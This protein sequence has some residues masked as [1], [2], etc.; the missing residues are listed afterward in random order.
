M[1]VQIVLDKKTIEDYLKNAV[2]QEPK[3]MVA[4]LVDKVFVHCGHIELIPHYADKPI[5]PKPRNDQDTENPESESL[6]GFLI[7]TAM[8]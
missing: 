2:K 1:T 5:K 3:I 6:R 7:F 4:L 8:T